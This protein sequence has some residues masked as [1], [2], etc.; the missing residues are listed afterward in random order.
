MFS[1]VV[2]RISKAQRAVKEQDPFAQGFDCGLRGP[3]ENNCHFSLFS[4]LEKTKAWA[5][6]KKPVRP[7]RLKMQGE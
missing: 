6:G 1:D 3:N 2:K 4:S 7:R 5:A